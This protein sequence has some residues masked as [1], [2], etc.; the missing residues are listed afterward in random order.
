MQLYIF[1]RKRQK[2]S[3][4]L[5][6][7]DDSMALSQV[8]ENYEHDAR[9]SY[10]SIRSVI[11]DSVQVTLTTSDRPF[12]SQISIPEVPARPFSSDNNDEQQM[13][14]LVKVKDFEGYVKRAIESGLLNKQYEVSAQNLFTI[15]NIIDR[16]N[17]NI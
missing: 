2:S 13:T 1:T 6:L 10:V 14:S 8:I 9:C 16:Q 3:R 5:R 17:I 11:S 15:Y 4:R 7:R 12:I